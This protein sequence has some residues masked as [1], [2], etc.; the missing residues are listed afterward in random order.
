MIS[1]KLAAE[2]KSINAMSAYYHDHI[3]VPVDKAVRALE[4]LQQISREAK[5]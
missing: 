2:K 3:F 5:S 1:N 4:I